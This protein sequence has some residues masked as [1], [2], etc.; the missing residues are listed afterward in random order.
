M[1]VVRD[2]VINPSGCQIDYDWFTTHD[3]VRVAAIVDGRIVVVEQHHYLFGPLLQLPGGRI[4]HGE[5]VLASARRE[6]TEETG[7]RGGRWTSRGELYP[8]P[9]LTTMRVHLW[10]AKN[11]RPGAASLEPGEQDLRVH[12][13][14]LSEAVSAVVR[15]RVRCAPSA[16]LIM[17]AANKRSPLSR[18]CG[19]NGERTTH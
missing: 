11:L 19:T 12:H 18:T 3:Q 6:L 7:Y 17:I 5:P 16:A 2:Q 15:G 4:E 10:I 1:S 13:Y 8:L 14:R 9:G